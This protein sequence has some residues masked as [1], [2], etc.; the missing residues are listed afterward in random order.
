MSE[1]LHD[2]A[3]HLDACARSSLLSSTAEDAVGFVRA[4][5]RRRQPPALHTLHLRRSVLRTTYRT[6]TAAGI[7]V[8]DPTRGLALPPKTDRVA[9]P[10]DDDELVLIRLAAL[11]MHRNPAIA[12][13]TVALAEAAASTGELPRI[14][15]SDIDLAGGHVT[16]PGVG[17]LLPRRAPLTTW[18]RHALTRLL[19][20]PTTPEVPVLHFAPSPPGSHRAQALTVR[21]IRRILDVAGLGAEADVKPNSIRL[22]AG[23]TVLAGGGTIDSVAERLGIRS[24]DAAAAAIG[25]SAP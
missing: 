24:L 18:G 16:L 21:R 3:T 23:A 12:A 6:I 7:D 14:R 15:P 17:R 1:I 22:W 13:A 9:R 10:V 20:R 19:D 4:P 8:A 2:Y 25:W 5:T 11:T